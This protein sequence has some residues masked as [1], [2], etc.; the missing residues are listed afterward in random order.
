MPVEWTLS[1]VLPIFMGKGDTSNCSY[2]RA[3]KLLEH[4]MNAVE[5]VLQ[6]TFLE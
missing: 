1:V 6:K 5:R 4:G 2:H 3:V